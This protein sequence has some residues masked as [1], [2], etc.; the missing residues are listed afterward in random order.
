MGEERRCTAPPAHTL[1]VTGPAEAG[2]FTAV[3][4]EEIRCVFVCGKAV[5]VG[6]GG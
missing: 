5:K 2:T 4:C 1:L 3:V 6:Y